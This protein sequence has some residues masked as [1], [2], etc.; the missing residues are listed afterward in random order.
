MADIG[1][2]T[3]GITC[4]PSDLTAGM[5][6]T[7]DQINQTT[8]TIQVQEQDWLSFSSSVIGSM[9]RIAGPAI[10]LVA[11]YKR[12][13][14]ATIAMAT[15]NAAATA[16]T[17]TLGA[18]VNFLLAPVTLTVG[19][20]ALLA[21]ALYYFSTRE[22]EG[23]DSTEALSDA[24]GTVAPHLSLMAQLLESVRS[25]VF[26]EEV[27]RRVGNV[28]SEYQKLWSAVGDLGNQLAQPFF[29]AASAVS[30]FVAEQVGIESML[31]IVTAKIRQATD[32]INW[33]KEI[34]AKAQQSFLALAISL[35]SGDFA[36]AAD[37]VA[38]GE[39]MRSAA[40]ASEEL[41]E[42]MEKQA[43]S[44]STLKEIQQE[45]TQDAQNAAEV[46]KIRS[47]VTIESIDAE[48]TA[49]QQRSAAAI[50]A[51]NA[52]EAWEQQTK[53]LFD[54]LAK[55]RQGV[56]DGTV[57][58][59]EAAE[60]KRELAKA[61]E[62]A[63]RAAQAASDAQWKT[64]ESGVEQ[65]KS[66]QDQIDLITGATTKAEIAKRKALE[67][68]LRGDQADLIGELTDELEQLQ[69]KTGTPKEKKEVADKYQGVGA[70]QQGSAEAASAIAKAVNQNKVAE[71]TLEVAKK[72][73]EA[74]NQVAE[75]TASLKDGKAVI[76][77]GEPLG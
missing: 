22:D 56:L 60:A 72:Q 4:D 17:L 51:G 55:Q 12:V 58:D 52:D 16:P 39:A 21:G 29:D 6:E 77:S 45:A 19:A 3:V 40:K 66:L 36:A 32:G 67:S 61:A 8:T 1:E 37:F 44:F 26:T 30:G 68:G 54:A 34:T 9:A 70:A 63:A 50:L 35:S 69:K 14:A 33:F 74:M 48:T 27:T 38:Q 53:A 31:D 57:I 5:T 23:A 73:E 62:E 49:L 13:Q 28:T 20:L 2:L 47:L 75:N 25:A 76:V 64:N 15:A 46:A 10:E 43:K 65:I 24:V 59:K 11:A 71:Q 42:K 7:R 41:T 18:A